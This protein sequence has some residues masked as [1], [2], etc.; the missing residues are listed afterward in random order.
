MIATHDA[1]CPRNLA[2]S[3]KHH[4]DQDVVAT[5]AACWLNTREVQER[6]NHNP[7]LKAETNIALQSVKL[8]YKGNKK[9]RHM[10]EVLIEDIGYDVLGSKVILYL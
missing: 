6:L 10:V 3:E 1:F 4:P 2:L 8:E 7:S 5:C 9:V